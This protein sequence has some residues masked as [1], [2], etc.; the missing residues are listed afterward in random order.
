M[1]C[2]IPVRKVEHAIEKTHKCGPL[3][4]QFVSETC[5]AYCVVFVV[6]HTG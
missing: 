3:F 1:G 4:W 2:Q 6:L 5:P